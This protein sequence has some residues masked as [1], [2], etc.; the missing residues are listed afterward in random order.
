MQGWL[1][2]YLGCDAVTARLTFSGVLERQIRNL[3]DI[4]PCA[5]LKD[6]SIAA[7]ATGRTMII[8]R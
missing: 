5:N 8:N 3:L 6:G 4:R 1:S 2:R 7:E